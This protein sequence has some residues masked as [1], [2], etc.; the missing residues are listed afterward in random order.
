MASFQGTR[1][2]SLPSSA[3][4]AL[5]PLVGLR[6]SIARCAADMRVF[7]FGEIRPHRNGRGAVG[8]YALHV[9]CPWRLVGADG[10]ITGSDDLYQPPSSDAEINQDDPQSGCLQDVRLAALLGGYDTITSSHINATDKLVVVAVRADQYGS[11][12]I[13]FSGDVS[14]QLFPASSTGENWRFFGDETDHFV[15]E[16]G[17]V[18]LD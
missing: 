17:G 11:A 6:L 16:G 8:E 18:A 1:S 2:M 12:E 7:H 15:I 13:I 9:Q 10:L 14:L 4:E 3:T 5:Q